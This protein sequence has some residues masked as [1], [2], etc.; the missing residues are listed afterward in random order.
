MGPPV[1]DEIAAALGRFF[2]G[3]EGPRHTDLEAV[4]TRTGFGDVAPYEPDQPNKETRV[5]RTIQAA[6]R[7]PARARELIDGLLA[8]MRAASCF[9]PDL[10]PR[11]VDRVRTTQKAFARQGWELSDDGQLRTAGVINLTTGGRAAL[12]EQLGRLQGAID[13][14]ALAIGSAK[15]LLEAIAK[16]V[17]DEIGGGAPAKADFDRLLFLARDRLGLDPRT[18]TDGQA[19]A[20]YIRPILGSAW[21]IAEQVNKLRNAQGTGHGR[22]LPTGVTPEMAVL[23]VREAC[24]VSELMLRAL[25]RALGR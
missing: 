5:R 3:G 2:T 11:D 10:P 22:T 6:C 23:V 12:D 24:N 19:G 21:K 15:D 8:E 7:R 25:D 13:D 9:S 14:P 1:S 20:A 16:F 17:L 18:V 4:F